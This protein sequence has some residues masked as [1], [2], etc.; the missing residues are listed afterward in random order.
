MSDEI[1][2]YLKYAVQAVYDKKG[3]NV[4]VLDVVG[5]CSMTDYVVIAEGTVDR[6]VKAIG[7]TIVEELAKH[8]FHPDRMEGEREGDWVVIDY[9]NFVVHLFVAELREKYALER[10]WQKGSIIDIPDMST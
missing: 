7:D 9:V 1:L 6:H 2:K 3:Y 10:L 8:N 5:V 4:I